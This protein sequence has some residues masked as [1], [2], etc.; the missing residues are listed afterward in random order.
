MKVI[1]SQ[2]VKGQG[3][4]GQLVDVS[5]GYA[6]NFLF[7]K[8]LAVEANASNMNEMK[9][10]EEALRHKRETERAAALAAAERFKSV[11][12]KVPAKGG[13]A[14]RL[15]G[16]VTSKE[17]AEALKEQFALDIDKRSIVLDE[18][19]RQFGAYELK[20][21]LFPEITATMRVEIVEG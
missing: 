21:K 10:R 13:S 15:F 12:V 5:D 7:P 17:I 2:D 8:K 14:G 4:K 11:S 9:N 6:K 19:I 1:L 20:I 18:P 3:K 16:S